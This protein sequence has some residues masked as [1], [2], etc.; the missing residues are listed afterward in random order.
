LPAT[1]ASPDASSHVITDV[2][3]PTATDIRLDDIRLDDILDE[4]SLGDPLPEFEAPRDTSARAPKGPRGR[5]APR[6]P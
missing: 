3:Q 4:L 5:K 1:P 2:E 6:Q